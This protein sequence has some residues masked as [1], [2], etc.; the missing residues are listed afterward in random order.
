MEF[1]VW[2]LHYDGRAE[3]LIARVSSDRAESAVRAAVINGTARDRIVALPSF[4]AA[5]VWDPATF[6]RVATGARR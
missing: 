2:V 5:D 3:T 6:R 1:T 4:V